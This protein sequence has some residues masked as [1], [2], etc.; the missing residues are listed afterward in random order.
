MA[1]RLRTVF[2]TPSIAI[3]RLGGSTTPLDAFRWSAADDPHLETDTAIVPAWS[4]DVQADGSVVPRMPKD[5]AFRDGALIR[6]VA[7]FLELW[8]L[9]EGSDEPVPVTP[10]VLEANRVALG[11]VVVMI[12]AMN[13][14]AARR[15]QNPAHR[16]GTFPA[17]EIRGDDFTAVPLLGESPAD[18]SPPMIPRGRSIPLGRVQLIRSQPQRRDAVWGN[19]VNVEV[20][21]LRFTPAAGLVYGPPAAAQPHRTPRGRMFAPVAAGQAFL[22]AAAGWAQVAPD[23]PV[24]PGDTYDGADVRGD[25]SLGVVDDTCDVRVRV[26]IPLRGSALSAVASIFVG[27]PEFA[28]D[29]RPFLSLADEL[30]DRGPDAVARSRGMTDQER[31]LWVEDLFERIHETVTLFNADRYRDENAA[32][33]RPSEI[34]PPIADDHVTDTGRQR[35]MSSRDL[36]RNR[37]L[38]IPKASHDLRLPISE[39]ARSRHSMLS[40]I[41]ELRNFVIQHPDRLGALVRR[42]F[43]TNPDEV[44]TRNQMIP[45]TM[46]MPPFMRNSNSFALTLARWQYDLLMDWVKDATSRPVKRRAARPVSR[47]AADRRAEV[48]RRLRKG[49][50]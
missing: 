15:T 11:D 45:T 14:K 38:Q 34:G 32:P 12:E 22:D 44:P 35:A 21:R 39:H 20:W 41:D 16:F 2:F 25:L 8:A 36:L 4:L 30:N 37:E 24:E 29:R 46:Q 40:D 1:N 31:D 50:R 48:L 27:P 23:G 47:E 49:G 5:L 19:E 43:T 13:R 6:P 17:V 7:P 3:A 42:P 18:A 9:V 28:P 33:L 10:A 26:T